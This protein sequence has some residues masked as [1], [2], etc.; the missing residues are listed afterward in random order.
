[1]LPPGGRHWQPT[2]HL[3][4]THRECKRIL[5]KWHQPLNLLIIVHLQVDEDDVLQELRRHEVVLLLSQHLS[6]IIK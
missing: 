3:G 2:K 6:T 4:T 1:M 5:R